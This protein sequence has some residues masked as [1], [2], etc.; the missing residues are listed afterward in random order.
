MLCIFGR[1]H[2][3]GI[4]ALLQLYICDICMLRMYFS[5]QL[6]TVLFCFDKESGFAPSVGEVAQKSVELYLF[7]TN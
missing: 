2:M 1:D 7:C 6:L 5:R 3:G 4:S